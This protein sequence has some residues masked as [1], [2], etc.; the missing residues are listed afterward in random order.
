MCSITN[1]EKKHVNLQPAILKVPLQPS[2][3]NHCGIF[4]SLFLKHFFQVFFD[5]DNMSCDWQTLRE[6]REGCKVNS[7]RKR[8]IT[9]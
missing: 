2:A 1:I 6:G 9:V 8:G 7:F 5:V 3:S 4:V